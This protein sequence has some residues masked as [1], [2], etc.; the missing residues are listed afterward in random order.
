VKNERVNL[1][2]VGGRE[3][4]DSRFVQILCETDYVFVRF[5]PETAVVHDQSYESKK[6]ERRV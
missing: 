2:M 5:E 4:W 1:S 3:Q 6:N